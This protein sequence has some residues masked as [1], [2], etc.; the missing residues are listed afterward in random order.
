[1]IPPAIILPL[2]VGQLRMA[3]LLAHELGHLV[4]HGGYIS[5][6]THDRQE[7]AAD[8][9]AARALIP[10]TA[11]Q[12]YQ[13]ASVD[14]FVG[15]LSKHYQDIPLRDCPERELAGTIARIRLSLVEERQD[16][17]EEAV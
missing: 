17:N 6:W 8:R 7:A 5:R 10:E 13:N 4:L 15:A 14:A 11:V 12:R 16:N 2:E 1:M 3:W 9:W